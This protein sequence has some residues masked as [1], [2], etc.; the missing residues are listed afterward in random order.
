MNRIV[1]A[2]N[3]SRVTGEII[4]GI[5]HCDQFMNSQRDRLPN[6]GRN[7]DWIQ[8]FIDKFGCFHDRQEAWKIASEAN[9]IWRRCGGD[10]ADGGTLYSENLY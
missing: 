7:A 2:A 3:K 8:G 4:L 5:R 9:Q 10:D 6:K 1:C